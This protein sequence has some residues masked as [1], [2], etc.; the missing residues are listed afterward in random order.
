MATLLQTS[1]LFPA[2]PPWLP[3]TVILA[4]MSILVAWTTKNVAVPQ[5]LPV[6]SLSS[7]EA[8]TIFFSFGFGLPTLS[9]ATIS[10]YDAGSTYA[11]FLYTLGRTIE[12][13]A[14]V[15]LFK[16]ISLHLRASSSG[17]NSSLQAQLLGAIAR[18]IKHRLIS[19]F[20]I[21]LTISA[22]IQ[23]LVH[24]PFIFRLQYEIASILTLAS[25]LV[26][27]YGLRVRLQSG[28]E[29]LPRTLQTGLILCVAGAE[30][31][32]HPSLGI[33]AIVYLFGVIAY[34]IGFWYATVR[35]I[36]THI[37]PAAGRLRNLLRSV[38]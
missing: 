32:D 13:V 16:K 11:A 9:I 27:Y 5:F 33:E 12:G 25:L 30:V 10:Y 24:G 7:W 29:G 26:S 6:T 19:V 3:G 35:I 36:E 18:R 8:K 1:A 21:L 2:I 34:T 23:I 17:S 31:Y 22:I 14:A 15:R 20:I 28:T 4:G 37:S 38:T